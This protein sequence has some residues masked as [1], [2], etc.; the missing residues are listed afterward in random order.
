MRTPEL[1]GGRPESGNRWRPVPFF[2][3]QKVNQGQEAR[4]SST[5]QTRT[6]DE[7]PVA[8]AARRV[9]AGAGARPGIQVRVRAGSA[10]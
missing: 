9:P 7:Q 10:G 5:A 3:E 1:P 2:A 6:D 4:E 8:A